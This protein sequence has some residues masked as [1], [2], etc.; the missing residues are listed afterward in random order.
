MFIK[1]KKYISL[2]YKKLFCFLVNYYDGEYKAF[3]LINE[4]IELIPSKKKG[5]FTIVSRKFYSEYTKTY[6]IKDKSELNKIL[7][8]ERSAMPNSYFE[9]KTSSD[10]SFVHW[11][12]LDVDSSKMFIIWPETMLMAKRLE[13]NSIGKFLSESNLWLYIK[14]GVLQST[15]QT[16]LI[17]NRAKL[18]L[19]LGIPENIQESEFNYYDYEGNFLKTSY[20]LSFFE[21]FKMFNIKKIN[22]L[23]TLKSFISPIVIALILYLLASSA[24]VIYKK[25][26]LIESNKVLSSN[27]TQIMSAQNELEEKALE[28]DGI[29]NSIDNHTVLSW[30]WFV[31][32]DITDIAKL[33]NIQYKNDRVIFRGEASK[34]TEVLQIISDNVRTKD[35]KF[36]RATSKGKNKERFVISFLLNELDDNIQESKWKS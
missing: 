14:N 21:V 13:T 4:E 1:L 28:Y 12:R 17:D 11:C 18:S 7:R 19:S 36:D 27:L 23:D 24:Y 2:L 3:V 15:Y 26:K 16:N 30:L 22:F 29:V 5:L 6:P 8:I 20:Q 34:A 25:E 33:S 35:A 9:I 31:M 32:G 10:T